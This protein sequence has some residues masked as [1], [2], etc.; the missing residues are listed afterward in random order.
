MGQSEGGGSGRVGSRGFE[1]SWV[2]SGRVRR[3][4][5]LTGRVGLDQE[6]FEIWR[7]GLGQVNKPQIFRGSGRVSCPDPIR[8]VRFGLTRE[9]PWIFLFVF[10]RLQA[11]QFVF[12]G[13]KLSTRSQ[14]PARATIDARSQ[15][16]LS[17]RPTRSVSGK[18][19]E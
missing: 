10:Q 17:S 15:H 11:A 12:S 4:S 14:K 18:A 6:P 9:K 2:R 5:N 13:C 8:P 7:V 19:N 1:I 3:F 16:R